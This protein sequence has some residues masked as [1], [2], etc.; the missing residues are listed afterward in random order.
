ML[1]NTEVLRIRRLMYFLLVG[2]VSLSSCMGVVVGTAVDATLEVAKVPFKV[3]ATAIDI[4]V[5]EDE[6]DDD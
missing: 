3:A 4:A 5:P 1:K 2:A 6:D